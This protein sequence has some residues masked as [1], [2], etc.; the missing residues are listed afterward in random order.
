MDSK[1][2]TGKEIPLG[3][4]TDYPVQYDKSVLFGISRAEGRQ[5]LGIPLADES[6]ALPFY[7]VDIWNG[8]EL[9]WL[10]NSGKPQVAVIRLDI[11]A[12]SPQIVESKSLKLYLNS[13]NQTVFSDQADGCQTVQ[14]DVSEVVGQAIKVQIFAP[15]Q[16]A[17]LQVAEPQSLCIDDQ[18]YKQKRG[19][20]LPALAMDGAQVEERLH[21]NLM[22]S[23][24]PVTSQPDWAT[25]YF[26]YKGSAIDH[27]ALLAYVIS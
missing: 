13:L 20:V 22:R 27:A 12:E 15:E 19:D 7:G 17:S 18:P 25:V 6:S 24:C 2:P 10:D 21:S 3:K 5:A 26:H 4:N 9:S 14:R 23:L 1:A 11:P 8:Y 16:W